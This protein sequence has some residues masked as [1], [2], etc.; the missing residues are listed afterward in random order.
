MY[1]NKLPTIEDGVKNSYPTNEISEL[2][3]LEGKLIE[4]EEVPGD[5]GVFPHNY[6]FLDVSSHLYR[7]VCPSVGRSVG[8][9]VRGR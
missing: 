7:S 9:S 3:M 8:R 5:V 2:S 6:T 1:G 4:G